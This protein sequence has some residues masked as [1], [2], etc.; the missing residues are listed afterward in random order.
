MR[1]KTILTLCCFLTLLLAGTSLFA[2]PAPAQLLNEITAPPVCS[3]APA[4]QSPQPALGL[5]GGS[6]A[7]QSSACPAAVYQACYQHYGSCTLCFCLGSSCECEN[8]CV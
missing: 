8:R 7:V 2:A 6:A 3:A 1:A 5:A 4:A